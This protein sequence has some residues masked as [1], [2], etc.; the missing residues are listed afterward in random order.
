MHKPTLVKFPYLLIYSLAIALLF[1][2]TWAYGVAPHP[3]TFIRQNTDLVAASLDV[4]P[5]RVSGAGVIVD[6]NYQYT[7]GE[8]L[9]IAIFRAMG[10]NSAQSKG[11]SKAHAPPI[12]HFEGATSIDFQ[13]KIAHKKYHQICDRRSP[14]GMPLCMEAGWK[15]RQAIA[16]LEARETWEAR[17][18]TRYTL[19]PHERALENVRARLKNAARDRDRYCSIDRESTE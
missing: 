18:G 12:R 11:N 1:P 3:A 10:R 19:A 7:T 6:N 4:G 16:C 14:K 8:L 17:W 9:G 5:G 2:S 13:A 15:Y